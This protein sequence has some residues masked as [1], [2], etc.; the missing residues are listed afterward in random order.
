MALNS[1]PHVSA[2]RPH[3]SFGQWLQSVGT[4][5]QCLVF[6]LLHTFAWQHLTDGQDTLTNVRCR[7]VT[8]HWKRSM[9]SKTS[10][11][12]NPAP[13]LLSYPRFSKRFRK[14]VCFPKNCE[15]TRCFHS[16]T[17]KLMHLLLG[18]ANPVQALIPTLENTPHVVL[19]FSASAPGTPCKSHMFAS[20]SYNDTCSTR[21]GDTTLLSV[22]PHNHL[23]CLRPQSARIPKRT[24]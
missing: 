16:R 4:A 21:R 11:V 24:L 10:T 5:V 3:E 13:A 6:L 22:S 1:K 19:P 20:K 17:P 9:S 15:T 8:V 23:K 7:T 18:F 2:Q 14:S 12:G